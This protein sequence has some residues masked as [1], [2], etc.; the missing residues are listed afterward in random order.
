VTEKPLPNVSVMPVLR[1]QLEFA[2][3][4]LFG[5]AEISESRRQEFLNSIEAILTGAKLEALAEFAAGA[6]HEINNPVAT[7]VG[8]SQL[9]LSQELDPNRTQALQIIGGQALRIR[10]MIADVMLFARP[11]HPRPEFHNLAELIA[12]AAESQGELIQLRQAELRLQVPGELMVWADR[13]QMLVL[14]SSLVRNCLESTDQTGLEIQVT[15]VSQTKQDQGWVLMSIVD[16]GP[17]IPPLVREH[18]FDPFF[19][20]RQAG[21]GLGFGLSKCWRIVQMHG[22][23]I[24]VQSSAHGETRFDVWL[25]HPAS[26]SE[27][28]A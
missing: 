6:G 13:T 7:I 27:S 5:S 15:A 8:R 28:R 3:A 22:G 4:E 1:Q 17:G 14:L 26:Q 19:S 23:N 18:L 24:D 21:R 9:L 10:D 11:P 2:C 16:N 20:G 25:P 12:K